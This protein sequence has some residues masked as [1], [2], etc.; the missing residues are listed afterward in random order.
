MSAQGPPPELL[1]RFWPLYEDAYWRMG[2]LHRS[3]PNRLTS[4]YRDEASNRA[5][6]GAPTSQHLL[7]LAGDWVVPAEYKGQFLQTA[8]FLGLVPVDEGSHIHV[9]R[10]AA[11]LLPASLFPKE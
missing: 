9:Q 2:M 4:F 10:Y 5:A 6:G 8:R 1:Y 7:G 11:G 3:C